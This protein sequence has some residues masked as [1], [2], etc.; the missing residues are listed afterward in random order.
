MKLCACGKPNPSQFA[1]CW[2]CAKYILNHY[3]GKL[4]PY[5]EKEIKVGKTDIEKLITIVKKKKLD[6]WQRNFVESIEQQY[7]TKNKL[8]DKQL[9]T[10]RNI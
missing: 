5:I 10:L 6:S 1:M 8:S 9:T 2:N 4:P 7:K 3:A